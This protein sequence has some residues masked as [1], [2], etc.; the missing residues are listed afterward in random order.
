MSIC[1]VLLPGVPYPGLLY[2]CPA[3]PSLPNPG[4]GARKT[5]GATD[6]TSRVECCSDPTAT[7][8]TD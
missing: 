6:D 8:W 3:V 1:G 7:G 4:A 5:T 2:A